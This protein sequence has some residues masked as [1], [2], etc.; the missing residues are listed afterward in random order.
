[1]MINTGS[2]NHHFPAISHNSL[3]YYEIADVKV[4]TE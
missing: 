1:M 4:N 2:I 3:N